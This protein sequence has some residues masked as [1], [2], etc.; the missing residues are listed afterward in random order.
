VDQAYVVGTPDDRTGEAV[1]AFV[2]PA[3]DR[4]PDLGALA[5][6][7]RAELGEECVPKTITV[8]PEAP[9]GAGGKPDKLALRARLIG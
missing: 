1:H 5:T 9:L 2:V 8:I 3:G 4:T 6:A 7:V